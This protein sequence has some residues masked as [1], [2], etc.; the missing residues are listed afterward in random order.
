MRGVGQRSRSLDEFVWELAGLGLV[1]DATHRGG[2]ETLKSPPFS[3]PS[4]PL[5]APPN[6][7]E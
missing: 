6:T 5:P 7:E 3:L 1:K 2:H 4:L